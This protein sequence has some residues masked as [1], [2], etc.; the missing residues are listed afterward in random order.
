MALGPDF[1]GNLLEHFIA[2]VSFPSSLPTWCCHIH[3]RITSTQRKKKI[4][5]LQRKMRA[6]KDVLDCWSYCGDTNL[7]FGLR[8]GILQQARARGDCIYFF[9]RLGSAPC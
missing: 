6:E 3:G 2:W 8:C 9:C 4:Q 5:P 1:F 7:L